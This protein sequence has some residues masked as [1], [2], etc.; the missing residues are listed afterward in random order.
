MPN[1]AII[2]QPTDA[3]Q[4]VVSGKNIETLAKSNRSGEIRNYQTEAEFLADDFSPEILLAWGRDTPDD[5]CAKMPQLR[6]IQSLSAGVEG[7][8]KL[9]IL[10]EKDIILGK[11]KSVHGIVMAQTCLAYIL[12]FVR[13]FPRLFAQKTRHEW[14]KPGNEDLRDATDMTVG[15][16]GIGDIGSDV[17][18][19]CSLC[20]M[21]VL[22][23]RRSAKPMDYVDQ[24][25]SLEQLEEMLAE[26]DFVVDL[27]PHTPET[28]GAV[29]ADFFKAMKDSAVFVNIGRGA[30]VDMKA[31]EEA[32]QQGVIA[33]AALD[34]FDQ[35]PLPAESPLWDMENVILTPHCSADNPNYFNRAFAVIAK[36]LEAYQDKEPIPTAVRQ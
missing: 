35:E 10:K 23:C 15:I 17:A 24:M 8:D 26:C 13:S 5:A 1:I 14:N 18:R 22:G 29:N 27:V 25:Y 3:H 4:M 11:M 34:A 31:L 21:R 30:T 36:S 12:C 6:W 19:L 16:Y 28:E 9:E 20:G 2:Y 32:L 33:G 7:L